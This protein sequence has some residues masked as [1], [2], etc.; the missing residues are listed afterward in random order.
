MSL[1]FELISTNPTI[2][3]IVYSTKIKKRGVL[4]PKE[5]GDLFKLKW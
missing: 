2:G 5:A 3:L 4:L 1:S